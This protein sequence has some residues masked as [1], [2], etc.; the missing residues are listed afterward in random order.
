M[1]RQSEAELLPAAATPAPLAAPEKPKMVPY[2]QLYRYADSLV[3]LLS[4]LCL[5]ACGVC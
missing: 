2:R 1:V 5:I 3:R 4:S